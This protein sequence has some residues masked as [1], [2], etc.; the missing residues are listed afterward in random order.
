MNFF[1]ELKRRRVF[2]V[3][4]VYLA[5]AFVVLQ[6]A[7]ILAPAL[8]L[9][10]WTMTFIVLL[11]AVGLVL[12]LVLSWVVDVTPD[13]L[14]ITP[15]AGASDQPPQPVHLTRR[16]VL[17]GLTFLLVVA[18]AGGALLIDT[19]QGSAVSVGV[20]PFA[21][22]SDDRSQ[23]YFGDGIAEELLNTLRL[24]GVQVASRTSSFA[25]KG[26]NLPQRQVAEELSV[27]HV[28]EG[29]VRKAGAQLRIAAQVVDVRTDRTVWSQ[30]F[31]RPAG[32][33]F[34][35]QAEIAQAVAEALR[36]RLSPAQLQVGTTNS[37]AYDLYLLGLFH[38]HG[39]T[40]EGLQR[41]LEYFTAARDADRSF[42]RAEAGLAFTW[43]VMPEY[44]GHDIAEARRLGLA[45]AQR[46]VALDPRSAEARTALG[47]ALDQSGDG[48]RAL[49]EFDRAVELDPGFATA[50]HW[51]GILLAGQGRFDEAEASIRT[52]RRLDP[53]APAPQVAL[54]SVLDM[55][56]RTAEGLAEL[57]QVLARAPGFRAMERAF[58]M[59]AVLG[60]AREY[61][62][63]LRSYLAAMGDDPELAP[64]IIAGVERPE[65]RP[66]AVAVMNDI[67][68]RQGPR[69]GRFQLAGLYALLHAREETL[70][71]LEADPERRLNLRRSANAFLAD[72]PRYR[73]M[74]AAA[75][76]PPERTR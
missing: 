43:R 75:D 52:A 45:A 68:K 40:P 41:A 42:A 34:A 4:L 57:D 55:T 33:I 10:A 56:G 21:D 69:R 60:K 51:R 16:T 38:W 3:V 18:L 49:T 73:A 14:E 1:H 39:R 36:V 27:N 6:A 66:A 22:M 35:I 48:A 30:T 32:D 5:A 53:A 7:D 63:W 23:E 11:L 64:A 74:L 44:R 54:G 37:R 8:N 25:F 20:L 72:D 31:D 24:A 29:S 71:L 76:Q 61:E 70:L 62:P 9:P 19:E 59:A 50:H 65:H 12:A 17:G 26:R 15:A 2:R 28:V 46:A 67:S 58:V 13:G 47:G